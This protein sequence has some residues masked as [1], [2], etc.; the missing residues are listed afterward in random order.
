MIP[1]SYAFSYLSCNL[2]T[3]TTQ[4]NLQRQLIEQGTLKYNN[5]KETQFKM[6]NPWVTP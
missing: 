4:S 5:T 1:S 3:K 2:N 6:K